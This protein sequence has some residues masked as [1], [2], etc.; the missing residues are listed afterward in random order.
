MYGYNDTLSRYKSKIFISFLYYRTKTGL[1]KGLV[2]HICGKVYTRPS[3]L[4]A[5]I[6]T[7]NNNKQFQCQ[8]CSKSFVQHYKLLRHLRFHAGVKEHECPICGACFQRSDNLRQ[9]CQRVHKDV[10]L[11]SYK[12]TFLSCVKKNF[13]DTRTCSGVNC[14]TTCK[15]KTYFFISKCFSRFLINATFTTPAISVVKAMA[16][17]LNSKLT[18]T[19]I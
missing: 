17:L 3:E 6:D 7:H 12:K 14:D 19:S 10:V 1:L 13:S 15:P 5:H 11:R 16:Q 18:W 4:R 2:C 9:H 8:M